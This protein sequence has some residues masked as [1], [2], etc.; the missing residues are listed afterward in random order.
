ML[1]QESGA[2]YA[3]NESRPSRGAVR[4]PES[5][6]F[7]AEPRRPR[8]LVVDDETRI[9]DSLC[10]ILDASGFEAAAAYDG[11]SALEAAGSFTPT[12]CSPMC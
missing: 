6:T 2:L 11:W 5:G 4:S 12:T 9:A 10:E 3:A 1:T 7:E 8:I